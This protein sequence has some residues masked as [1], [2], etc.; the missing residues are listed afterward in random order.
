MAMHGFSQSLAKE[1][2]KRN[3]M[4]NTIAPLAGTR[5]TETVMPKELTNA[6][7]PEYVAPLVALLVHETCPESGQLFEVG[8]GLISKL[9]W[10]RSNGKS[11]DLN[12]LTPES[13]RAGWEEMA[14]WTNPS[15]P[16]ANEEMLGGVMKNIERATPRAPPP[17]VTTEGGPTQAAGNHLKSNEIFQM[18]SAYLNNGEGKELIPKVASIFGFEIT[19]KKGG[20]IQGV[21]EI[22][23]KNGQGKVTKGKPEKADATFTMT[24]DDFE[25]VTLG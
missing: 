14:S 6:L 25:K 1:G 15:N 22:D 16:T 21:W 23:L 4:V 17:G 24:D 8:G 18:M 7:K 2:A 13:I 19:A 11:F 9:R 12:K 10:Q 5:M 20:P 3:I